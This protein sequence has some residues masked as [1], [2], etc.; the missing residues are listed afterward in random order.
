MKEQGRFRWA[1]IALLHGEGTKG[2]KTSFGEA[3]VPRKDRRTEVLTSPEVSSVLQTTFVHVSRWD[4][5][6][7]EKTCNSG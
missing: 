5:V 1:M 2:P 7:E 6:L 4:P 3:L